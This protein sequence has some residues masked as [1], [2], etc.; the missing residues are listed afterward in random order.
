MY[1]FVL[2]YSYFS[3]VAFGVCLY[4]GGELK[5]SL[6]P[7]PC[8]G[9]CCKESL[10]GITKAKNTLINEQNNNTNNKPYSNRCDWLHESHNARELDQRPSF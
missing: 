6:K 8:L 9:V 5:C 2:Y 4:W 7:L 3:V 1:L 10:F